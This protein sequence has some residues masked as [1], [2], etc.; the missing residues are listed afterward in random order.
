MMTSSTRSCTLSVVATEVTLNCSTRLPG[1]WNWFA[2]VSEPSTEYTELFDLQVT[3]VQTKWLQWRGVINAFK[4]LKILGNRIET[5]GSRGLACPFVISQL[6]FLTL[7]SQ[8]LSTLSWHSHSLASNSMKYSIFQEVLSQLDW[9]QFAQS[10]QSLRRDSEVCTLAAG[11]RDS[12]IWTTWMENEWGH[13]PKGKKRGCC[14]KKR[15]HLWAGKN[16]KC[17]H[18]VQ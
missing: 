11:C 16:N 17:S 14:Q 2:L 8:L 13:F 10:S 7:L 3:E 15:E 12:P 6:C 9:L 1:L 18:R 4:S 5:S